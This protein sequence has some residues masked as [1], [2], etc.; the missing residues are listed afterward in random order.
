MTAL[1]DMLWFILGRF[2]SAAYALA[3]E[4]A[5]LFGFGHDATSASLAGAVMGF[6]MLVPPGVFAASML[7][8]MIGG[9][10][11]MS[12]LE[13]YQQWLIGNL[14]CAAL[15]LLALSM[16]YEVFSRYAFGQPTIWAFELSYM[17]MGTAFM[18]SI[19]YAIREDQHVRMDILYASMRHRWRATIDMGA[20]LL[21]IPAL[22]WI[23]TGM[24]DYFHRS[25][26]I[27]ER[28]AISAWDPAVWPLKFI[29]M[30]AVEIILF[31]V[32]LT[33]IENLATLVGRE[34]PHG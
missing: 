9:R 15:V 8:W 14:C 18:M 25:F 20:Y 7:V 10:K 24:I 3:S 13:A 17:L 21:L 34:K 32:L 31:R 5:F 26:V 6:V 4:I 28:S 33:V 2:P 22:A 19:A 29:L 12:D 23:L 27:R 1:T 11:A 16:G 30:L